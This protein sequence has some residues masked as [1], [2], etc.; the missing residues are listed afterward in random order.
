MAALIANRQPRDKEKVPQERTHLRQSPALDRGAGAFAQLYRYP[1]TQAGKKG[2]ALDSRA[3]C[4]SFPD[5]IV[6]SN[7]TPTRRLIIWCRQIIARAIK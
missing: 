4:G 6:G 1:I 7:S 2:P 3:T 5:S